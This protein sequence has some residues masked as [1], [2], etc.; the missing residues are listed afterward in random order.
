[1]MAGYVG[2]I[3]HVDLT[4]QTVTCSPLPSAFIDGFIGGRGINSKL[5]HDGLGENIDPLGPENLL[6]F[7]VGPL[8]GTL[9]PGAGRYTV[10]S[11]S[12]LTGLF[13]D[14]NA[15]GHF[16]PELKFA[17]ID[18]L[19]ITGKLA[20]PGYLYISN[21]RAE[22]RPADHLWGLDTWQTEDRL[23]RELGDNRL[24]VAAIGPAG[25]NR[26]R[27]AC[28][29]N[30]KSRAAGRTGLG[31]VMG[32]KRLKAVVVRGTGAVRVA[33]P[34]ALKRLTRELTGKIKKAFS[35]AL[36]SEY[37]T[38]NFTMGTNFLGA[39]VIRNWSGSADFDQYKRVSPQ[40][41][42]KK[43]YVKRK[44]CFACPIAC[45]HL[46]EVR[47]GEFAG[48]RGGGLEHGVTTPFGIGC[49]ISDTNAFV[50]FNN[51]CNR[52]GVD[53][54]EFGLMMGAV[55]EWSQKGLVSRAD[56]GGRSLTWGDY[57]GV[58]QLLDDTVQRQGFGAVLALGSLKAAEIVGG[59]AASYLNHIKGL[60]WGA[61]DVRPFK[62]Y[63]LSL[64]TSTRGADHL[65]GM[66]TEE[67]FYSV[68]DPAKA[69]SYDKADLVIHY[70][71]INT[72]AD[73]LGLCKFT[74][75][76]LLQAVGLE[77]MSAIYHAVT[78]EEKSMAALIRAADRIYDLERMMHVRDGVT[79]EDDLPRGKW[80]HEPVQ[81]G[82]FK[83]EFFD[84]ALFNRMLDDYYRRRGWDVATGAPQVAT[85]P[86]GP[87]LRPS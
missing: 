5:V 80:A 78:G 85:A 51:N 2:N 47:D 45:G 26:V 86:S 69:I 9:A 49:G 36:M 27:M 21:G 76:S 79:R 14:A 16:G 8:V 50:R 35:Y 44:G 60:S 64:A 1:M 20:A 74:T 48:E 62:G 15:G 43:H 10:S 52:Y 22:F 81:D 11:K 54:L 53:A 70:Q 38:Q 87:V 23:R 66:P 71:R 33:N 6:V 25:E 65:R 34:E 32:A 84:K 40:L 83:G 7:G 68:T 4:R 41:I 31:A 67:I 3:M 19:I 39:L 59:D 56:L 55:M 17:G 42:R 37:G 75:Q 73:A 28:I 63:A 12:P 46:C 13:A 82:P 57:H 30:N 77:D 72:L 18:H 61:D 58:L 29:I 24:Q